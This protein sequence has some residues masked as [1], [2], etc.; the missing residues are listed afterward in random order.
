MSGISRDEW[1]SALGAV[2]PLPEFHPDAITITEFAELA[3]LQR[4]AA[5]DRMKALVKAGK[6][7]RVSKPAF[8]V[9]GRRVVLPAYVLIKGAPTRSRR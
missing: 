6:A 7:R 9:C 2:A 3:G 1:L 5:K 8:D 4:T